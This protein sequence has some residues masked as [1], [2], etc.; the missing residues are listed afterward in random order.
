M[1]VK[2]ATVGLRCLS[3]EDVKRARGCAERTAPSLVGSARPASFLRREILGRRTCVVGGRGKE[4]EVGVEVEIVE[5]WRIPILFLCR[6]IFRAP[7]FLPHAA[8]DLPFFFS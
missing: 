6:S 3:S 7:V 2:K 4:E 8:L 1:V 5:G